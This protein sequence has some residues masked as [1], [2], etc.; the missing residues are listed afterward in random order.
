MVYSLFFAEQR[1]PSSSLQLRVDL[2]GSVIKT[3]TLLTSLGP[4]SDPPFAAKGVPEFRSATPQRGLVKSPMIRMSAR[5][6]RL[7]PF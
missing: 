3:P 2:T 1:D 4:L 5:A 6:R 7:A